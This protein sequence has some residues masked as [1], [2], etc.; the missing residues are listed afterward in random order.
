MYGY[1]DKKDRQM[2]KFSREFLCLLTGSYSGVGGWQENSLE[3]L[4]GRTML[5][6]RLPASFDEPS[7]G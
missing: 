4:F 1:P 6:C 3:N 5:N 7:Y 2:Y